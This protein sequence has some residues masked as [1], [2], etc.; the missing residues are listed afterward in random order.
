MTI[1]SR[2]NLANAKFMNLELDNRPIEHKPSTKLLG[3]HI[4]EMLTWDNQIKH[5][6]S[7]VSNGLRML[8]LARKLTDNQETLKTIYYSLV[9]P[10]FD[11]CDVVWGDCSKTRADKLQKL[12]N[13]AARIITRANYSIRS[14]DVLNIL[15][16]SKLEERRKRHLLVTMFKVFNNTCPTYLRERFHRTSEIHD[17]NLRGSDYDLHLPLP[18]P[19]FLKSSANYFNVFCHLTLKNHISGVIYSSISSYTS[20]EREKNTLSKKIY[21]GGRK[22]IIFR[23]KKIKKA[24]FAL[25]FLKFLKN[26]I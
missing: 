14:S 23:H 12:Q 21:F 7:K 9:Q 22:S 13:R 4:D 15:E 3:V 6:S 24:N 2:Q 16:W 11:Y 1:G 8:Y 19:N 20:L 10:Y 18:N 25:K 17:Y 26:V 5:I